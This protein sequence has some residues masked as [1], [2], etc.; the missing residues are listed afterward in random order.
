MVVHPAESPTLYTAASLSRSI[1]TIHAKAATIMAAIGQQTFS[2]TRFFFFFGKEPHK[3][4]SFSF[5]L[6]YYVCVYIQ[7]GM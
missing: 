4:F 2:D 7:G 5:S 6:S 1:T 3:V